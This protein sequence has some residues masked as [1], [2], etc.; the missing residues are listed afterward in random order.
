MTIT[1]DYRTNAGEWS[2]RLSKTASSKHQAIFDALVDDIASGRLRRGDR[3]PPQR[4]IA[5]AL[6]VDLTTVTKAYSRA[7]EE[8]IIEA[9]TGRGSF[10]AIGAIEDRA[11]KASFVAHDLSRNSPAR[12]PRIDAAFVK[13]VSLALSLEASSGVM[14]YQDTGGNWGNRTAGST[15]LARRNI[16][17]NPDRV[18]LT[19]GAQSALYAICHLVSRRSRNIC[20]GQFAYPG[21]HTVAFQQ[22]LQLVPLSMDEKGIIP[23][24]FAEACTRSPIAALYVT[25][26]ADN[27]TA[28]TL[29]TDRRGAIV[30]IARQHSVPIIEDDPYFDLIPEAPAPIAAVAP[31][32]TW[33]IATASKCLS[34]ALRLGYVVAPNV[35]S[36]SQVAGALQALTMMA[37]PLFAAIASRWIYSGFMQEAASELSAENA[38]RQA[39][40]A[41]VF[42][43]QRFEAQPRT[44]HLWLNLPSPWRAS[45]FAHQCERRGV[46][47]VGSSSFSVNS[48]VVEAVRIS[49]GAAASR[50]ALR[51]A[52]AIMKSVLVGGRSSASRAMV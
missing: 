46:I 33:Y 26:T 31:D 51:D 39:I 48:P 21:I 15:W 47:T 27:P 4:A 1:E 20:V 18:V 37:S 5:A 41:N 43:D 23:E 40:A 24:S 3:L 28:V 45:E 19:S 9:T 13:E 22:G 16:A 10:V 42:N 34:P 25:P 11:P 32:I 49:V 17:A 35:E 6:G 2:P 14:N 38:E 44:P 52:L 8:G 29:P 50:E 12:L 7:R 36:A 30:K